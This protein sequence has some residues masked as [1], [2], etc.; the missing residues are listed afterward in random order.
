MLK[1]KRKLIVTVALL[2]VAVFGVS[3]A[4]YTLAGSGVGESE[5]IDTGVQK[6]EATLDGNLG[7]MEYSSN[8]DLIIEDSNKEADY[9]YN[10]VHIIPAN[11]TGTH[12]LE[13]Y[14]V[15]D[16]KNFKNL[17][18]DA[19]SEKK[20][21]MANDKVSVVDLP[22]TSGVDL[23]TEIIGSTKVG[24][25]LGNADLIYIEAPTATAYTGSYAMSDDLY[26]YIKNNYAMTDH[27]PVIIDKPN[28]SSGPVVTT[29]TFRTLIND[30]ADRYL[31][32]PVFGWN[33]S[34]QSIDNFLDGV[35][36]SHYFSKVITDKAAGSVLVLQGSDADAAAETA[37][38]SIWGAF[39][40]ENERDT[41]LSLAKDE[42]VLNRKK[43]LMDK[44][45]YG[46]RS[47]YPVVE[48]QDPDTGDTVEVNDF[49]VT[50]MNISTITDASVLNGYEFIIIENSAVKVEVTSQQMESV[51]SKLTEMAN[52]KQ[53]IIYDSVNVDPKSNDNGNGGNKY[54]ELYNTFVTQAD[55]KATEDKAKYSYILPVKNGFFD[56]DA[57]KDSGADSIA[58]LI[59]G[60]NYRGSE[61]NGRNG[62]KYRVLEIQPC[63][64]I[65][66]DLA[67]T[68]SDMKGSVLATNMGYKGNYYTNPGSMLSNTSVD[69]AQGHEYYA[70]EMTPAKVAKATGLSYNQI[71]VDQ[72]STDEFISKKDV[73]LDTYDLVYIGG[74]TSA[75][76]PYTLRSD[77]GGNFTGASNFDAYNQS[78]FVSAF[79]M[80]THTGM[81][82]HLQSYGSNS[83]IG[84]G[85]NPYGTIA[86]SQGL[87]T[88]VLMNGNDITA[89][90]LKELKDYID[91]GMPILFS[92]KVS[93]AYMNVY[94]QSRLGK[95]MAK[96]IDPDS[97][98]FKL[99]D[100]AY[101]KYNP[102]EYK[103]VDSTVGATALSSAATMP[104]A[105]NI[106]WNMDI[107]KYD[108][109]N[110]PDKDPNVVY[111]D[112]KDGKYGAN[113]GDYVTVFNKKTAE[114]IKNVIQSSATRPSLNI[115]S[116]P[117]D[118]SRGDESTYNTKTD[119]QMIIKGAVN[120][121][122]LGGNTMCK[123][124]LYV[125]QDGNG[126]FDDDEIVD[127]GAG[128]EKIVTCLQENK[129]ASE[130]VELTYEFPQDD[131]YGLVSWKLVASL[132]QEGVSTAQACDVK[133][134]YAYYKREDEVEKKEVR[135]L[136]IMPV[137]KVNNAEFTAGTQ[138]AHTLYMCTECQ[139]AAYK[140]EYNIV[141]QAANVFHKNTTGTKSE[142]ANLKNV[143]LH[144]HKFG[145]V[146]Y[147]SNGQKIDSADS[148]GADDWNT[149]F[150]DE[151][152][153]DY[154]F[155]LDIMLIDEFHEVSSIVEANGTSDAP[156]TMDNA[157]GVERKDEDGNKIEPVYTTDADGAKT[158]ITWVDYYQSKADGYYELWQKAKGKLDKS[159]CVSNM[160]TFL[161]KL[162]SEVGTSGKTS[163]N[164]FGIITSDQIQQWIDH[165]AYYNY[166]MYYSGYYN[167]DANYLSYYEEWVKLHD[168][169]VKNHNLYKKYSCYAGTSDNWLGANYD[170]VVLGFAEDFGGKDLTVAECN[171]VK[172]YVEDGGSLLATHDST[173]RYESSGSVN[174]T[175]QLRSVFGI[176]RFHAT[177][178]SSNSNIP[179]VTDRTYQLIYLKDNSNGAY[180]GPI[181]LTNKNVTVDFV[182][183]EASLIEEFPN[184][185][186]KL[187]G[188]QF[189]IYK[190]YNI[191]EEDAVSPGGKFKLSIR[192]YNTLEDAKAGKTSTFGKQ[193]QVCR[194]S[195]Q[196][197]EY[198]DELSFNSSGSAVYQNRP[199]LDSSTDTIMRY[200]VYT[201][202]DPKYFMT[203]KSILGSS[204]EDLVVWQ[205]SAKKYAKIGNAND[206]LFGIISLVGTTDSVAI[207]ETASHLNSPYKY[208]EF[209]LQNSIKYSIG[210]D[211]NNDDIGG[212]NKATQVNK[213]IVT[214][215]PFTLGDE[216]TIS[217]THAQTY[218]ADL[219]DN[220]MAVW[221]ALSGSSLAAGAFDAKSR[222]S[223]YAA[224]PN[225]GMDNY[226]LYSYQYGK[227]TVHYCGAG[228]SV[229][230]GAKKNNNDERMLYVNIVIDSV[231]NSGSK[232]KVVIKDKD[233]N[234]IKEDS[235]GALRLNENGDYEYKLGNVT[236]YPEF[237][238]DVKFSSL[239]GGL[240]EVYVFYDMNYDSINPEGDYSNKYSEDENHVLIHHYTGPFN[241]S[242]D[243]DKEKNANEK[244]KVE[245]NKINVQLRKGLY[246]E[247]YKDKNGKEEEY[248][249]LGLNTKLDKDGNAIDYFKNYGNYTYIVVWAKDVQGKTA[250]ARIKIKLAQE[251]F[252][253]TDNTIITI[254]M[255]YQ[256][257]KN[258]C[259]ADITDRYRFNM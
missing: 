208:V 240:S 60:S 239:S 22:V 48:T 21:I 95:L 254:P 198:L 4:A 234:E 28:N 227:G 181:T 192:L 119:N 179:T 189:T 165:E 241:D 65:D 138:D 5:K 26:S 9:M 76:L 90:K 97:N 223:L 93:Q 197:F 85:G 73:V 230:T 126:S 160:V 100:Y 199:T 111:N 193:W 24:E 125:D 190:P 249:L 167:I 211:Y 127:G 237:N 88:D 232:P 67:A 66:M 98:M 252:D 13:T 11:L 129:G 121:N 34:N 29:K 256:V 87:Y 212:T 59:N 53:Y 71:Q 255:E 14:A 36:D 231:R 44:I 74:N 50:K 175:T 69:E 16:K 52:D 136:Q 19:H 7:Y 176:D 164:G 120:A 58:A 233:N 158:A 209:N 172:K 147:D 41:S 112:N 202:S 185:Q 224:S 20:G 204:Q 94:A 49:T 118:Y 248:D 62:K 214:T 32:S 236:E 250:F 145:I 217:P 166:F 75:L 244:V 57:A 38:A 72:M 51:Y 92:D 200:P 1:S 150:A 124:V 142:F 63:Y 99:L 68:K 173:T 156:V 184:E 89:I 161:Q 103:G 201:F 186:T 123:L 6:R 140:A 207:Y 146:K 40:G 107:S 130:P 149:N 159:S 154:D 104:A 259:N 144:E 191:T 177:M 55:G 141:S 79:D 25:L 15:G 152:A 31:Y 195:K 128:H 220:N 135:T 251:L 83:G 228:H 78:K 116:A 23:Q 148:D 2:I 106:V 210:V 86:N 206:Q 242:T 213:G 169:V 47:H 226:F 8:I 101:F 168:E 247:K 205:A 187:A 37:T 114:A 225:D 162:Q 46:K 12:S 194:L 253:L 110:D 45:Y 70:F 215:Y 80:Y 115:T 27:K 137:N 105:V 77:Y 216:L 10:I 56:A 139:L 219:E 171:D 109:D 117:K 151:L 108:A 102:A 143:G 153:K 131:F 43:A 196:E 132:Y 33:K 81:A 64:P 155:D 157:N 39:T 246:K 182:K 170:M 96:D 229:V 203:Q 18:I 238:F 61:T 257:Q 243:E 122:T 42:N 113:A 245:E 258:P 133:T 35:G 134:G 54:L 183:E 188:P 91:S 180:Y 178:D 235:E 17:V 218:A 84:L 82:T 174:I 222:S 221:Y 3:V 30:I 163:P